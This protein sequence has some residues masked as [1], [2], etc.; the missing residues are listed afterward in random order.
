MACARPPKGKRPVLVSVLN[1]VSSDKS[2]DES[3]ILITINF[4]FIFAIH[5]IFH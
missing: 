4:V 5:Y 2:Q 1:P 3:K